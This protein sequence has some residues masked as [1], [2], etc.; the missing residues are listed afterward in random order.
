MRLTPGILTYRKYFLLFLLLFSSGYMAAQKLQA[1]SLQHLLKSE[2]KDTVK[3]RLMWQMADAINLFNPDSAINLSQQAYFLAKEINYVEGES[4]SIAA[5]AIA[6]TKIGNYPRALELYIQRLQ[7]E[8]KRNIPRN[9]ASVL[10]DIGTV[11]VLQEEYNKALEYYRDAD[12]VIEQNNVEYMKYYILLNL[13][14]VYNRLDNSDSSF[15]YFNKSLV[16]ARELQDTDLIASSMTGLGHSYRKLGNY[17]ESFINYRAAIIGLQAANDDEILCEATLGLAN[18]FQQLK[19]NDST[20][21]YAYQSLAIARKDN[22]LSAEL[23]AASFL[24]NHYK[25]N[26]NVDSAFVYVKKEQEL[27]DSINSKSR[28]RQS[29]IIATNEQ[30][31]QLEIEENKKAAAKERHQ[32]L[33]LLFIGIFIPGFFVLTLLLSRIKMHVRIIK[34]MGILSLLILFEYL[35]LLLHPYVLELTN[36]TPVFEI[37]IFVAIA[38]IIIPAHHRIEHWLIEKLTNRKNVKPD[39]EIRLKTIKL[40]MKDPSA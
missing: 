10:M 1:D 27:N 39:K 9:L 16:R 14:D 36:H 6:F 40:K 32:Q 4:R 28:I 31:R 11:H 21:Y 33:Q 19:K 34:V 35:T 12:S 2:K 26:N 17:D 22:F 8:E 18:L 37:F 15:K 29:Q 38:A 7:L 25:I 24:T 5:M 23:E 30:L 20:V 3:V 13:G